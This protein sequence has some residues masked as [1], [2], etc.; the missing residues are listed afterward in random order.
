MLPHVVY[1]YPVKYDPY[2][3]TTHEPAVA[4]QEINGMDP[5]GIVWRIRLPAMEDLS[6]ARL[7]RAMKAQMANVRRDAA[8]ARKKAHR[9]A[10]AQEAEEI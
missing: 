9:L 2:M 5:D 3:P 8:H 6:F 7:E 4:F 10:A 1:P